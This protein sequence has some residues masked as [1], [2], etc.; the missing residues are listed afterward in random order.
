MAR[1]VNDGKLP[2]N[3][4]WFCIIF[5]SFSATI[6]IL[7]G[8]F[9]YNNYLDSPAKFKKHSNYFLSGMAFGIAMYVTPNWT[10][11]RYLVE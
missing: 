2:P 10:I 1:F 11:P 3:V 9:L 5:G 4:L 6:P 7:Q 8:N